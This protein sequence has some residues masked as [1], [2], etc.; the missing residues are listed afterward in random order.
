MEDKPTR[1]PP[2]PPNE[3]SDWEERA[4]QT[5]ALTCTLCCSQIITIFFGIYW[6][7]NPDQ[8]QGATTYACFSGGQ[9]ITSDGII[10]NYGIKAN[11]AEE[12]FYP[13]ATLLTATMNSTFTNNIT[14]QF[15][16]WF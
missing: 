16:T 7:N 11:N 5:M 2:V 3:P 12:F 10:Y 8:N 1:F 13:D 15:V 4:K 14:S 9:N 6:L